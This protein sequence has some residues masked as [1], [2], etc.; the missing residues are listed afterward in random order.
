MKIVLDTNIILIALPTR[1]P[2]RIIFDS[3][4]AGNF[5][6]FLSTSILYEY[7][8]IIE[9]KTNPNIASNFA[10]LLLGLKNVKFAEPF[11][12]WNLIQKDKDDNKFVDL[13]LAAQVDYLVTNDKHFNI[14]KDIDFPKLNTIGLEDFSNLLKKEKSGN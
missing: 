1:S 4:L 3:L 10:E 7:T 13:A 9:N 14:L 6:L 12:H 5:D 11:Y 2:Y 8:E